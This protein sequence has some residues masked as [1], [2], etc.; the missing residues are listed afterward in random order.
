[1]KF[2]SYTSAFLFYNV[3]KKLQVQSDIQEYSE[4]HN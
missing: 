1:M 2:Y 3:S 4:A